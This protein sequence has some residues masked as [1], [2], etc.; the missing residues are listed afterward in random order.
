MSAHE[1]DMELSRVD[2]VFAMQGGSWF[3]VTNDGLGEGGQAEGSPG[4]RGVADGH[5]PLPTGHEDMSRF[6]EEMNSRVEEERKSRVE[7]EMKSRMEEEERRSRV[8]EEERK[9]RIEEELLARMEEELGES[10]SFKQ[11]LFQAIVVARQQAE[12][13]QAERQQQQGGELPEECR[14][15]SSNTST[16]MNRSETGENHERAARCSPVQSQARGDA[17]SMRGD[18]PGGRDAVPFA[19]SNGNFDRD[20][21]PPASALVWCTRT[22]EGQ[23]HSGPDASMRPHSGVPSSPERHGEDQ[24]R[25]NSRNRER[26]RNTGRDRDWGR[27]R[28]SDRNRDRNS[29]RHGE[30]DVDTNTISQA[31]SSSRLVHQ[32]AVLSS[33]HNVSAVARGVNLGGIARVDSS[34]LGASNSSSGSSVISRHDEGFSGSGLFFGM[35]E[36]SVLS[37]SPGAPCSPFS[38]AP[39]KQYDHESEAVFPSPSSREDLLSSASLSSS[40]LASP[41]SAVGGAPSPTAPPHLGDLVG[42][43]L[44]RAPPSDRKSSR[45]SGHGGRRRVSSVSPRSPTAGSGQTVYR[46]KERSA[47][48]S[49]QAM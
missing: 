29:E 26:D 32:P 44:A 19:L 7:E 13:A 8:E 49:T 4:V 43:K 31:A 1:E 11:E 6:A 12:Q 36:L 40:P 45:V 37:L 9:S 30:R 27:G 46:G 35:P 24:E 38:P 3:R 18:A 42:S 22:E 14:I 17:D 15:V 28:V 2:A 48:G 20:S 5:C 34:T 41:T 23:G 39:Q 10:I 16:G 21:A 33:A 25:E 47:V